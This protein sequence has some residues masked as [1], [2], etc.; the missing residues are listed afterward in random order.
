MAFLHRVDQEERKTKSW[1]GSFALSARSHPKMATREAVRAPSLTNDSALQHLN[2]KS[3]SYV[4]LDEDNKTKTP[5][6]GAQSALSALARFGIRI[7]RI[8]VFAATKLVEDVK[9]A[10]MV[11][12][13]IRLC[14]LLSYRQRNLP[15]NDSP[16]NSQFIKSVDKNSWDAKDVADCV[17]SDKSALA[18]EPNI[19]RHYVAAIAERDGR[20]S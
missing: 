20:T 18:Q 12:D 9:M 11:D 15:L 13:L 3:F 16:P 7:G 8:G 5:G 2:H 14:T 6:L 1:V 17:L 4:T 19:Y 10:S